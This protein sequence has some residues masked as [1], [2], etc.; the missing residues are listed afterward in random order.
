MTIDSR[1]KTEEAT[2]NLLVCGKFSGMGRAHEQTFAYDIFSCHLKTGA[3][4]FHMRKLFR[5]LCDKYISGKFSQVHEQINM[6]T[7]Q[8]ATENVLVWTR[9]Y[10]ELPLQPPSRSNV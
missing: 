2:A 9:L 5:I 4:V 3:P 1:N 7:E 6:V 10:N 8:L